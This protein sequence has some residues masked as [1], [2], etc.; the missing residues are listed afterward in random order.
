MKTMMA[1]S[2]KTKLMKIKSNYAQN[3]LSS[4]NSSILLKDE[5]AYFCDSDKLV[6]SPKRLFCDFGIYYSIRKAEKLAWVN[7]TL[8]QRRIP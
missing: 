7:P 3:D 4:P 2:A 8:N 6:F 1:D 5:Y